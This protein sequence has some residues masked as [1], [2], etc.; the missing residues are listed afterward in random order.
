MVC[1]F[2]HLHNRN[3]II[4]NDLKCDNIVLVPCRTSTG[5]VMTLEKHVK[6]TR[7]KHTCRLSQNQKGYYKVNHPHI[8]PDLRDGLCQQSELSDVYS[9]G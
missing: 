4:H 5:A 1:G 9:L 2:E 8:T 3:K 6:P 7:A